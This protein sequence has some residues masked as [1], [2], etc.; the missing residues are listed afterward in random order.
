[1]SDHWEVY[2]C[3]MGEH[4]AFVSY[5]HGI[6]ESL[7]TLLIQDLVKVRVGLRAADERGLPTREEFPALNAIEDT[8][9]QFAEEHKGVL[10][11][12][13]TVDGARHLYAYVDVPAEVLRRFLIDAGKRLGY[14]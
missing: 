14:E 1:M 13:V 7:A 5:D 10:V 2:A 6:G 8:F 11:G 9:R 3:Q 12:R 4:R